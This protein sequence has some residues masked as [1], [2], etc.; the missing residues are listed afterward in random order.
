MQRFNKLKINLIER[1]DQLEL[2]ICQASDEEDY[3][4]ASRLIA[5]YEEVTEI[6]HQMC[7]SPV[8]K[9][10]TQRKLRLVR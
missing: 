1:K 6:L 8:V 2:A 5:K 9:T 7:C 4:E 10:Y 3:G